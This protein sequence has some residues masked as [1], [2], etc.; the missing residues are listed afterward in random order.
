MRYLNECPLPDA[1]KWPHRDGGE[2]EVQPVHKAVI[3]YGKWLRETP[4]FPG[5]FELIHEILDRAPADIGA[6]EWM[7]DELKA[8]R[9]K[10]PDVNE[11]PGDS[12]AH[13]LRRRLPITGQ[14]TLF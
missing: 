7:A 3:G 12:L 13:Q 14:P 8:L 5:L 4:Y 11:R 9:K 10:H 2:R 1:F 6:G